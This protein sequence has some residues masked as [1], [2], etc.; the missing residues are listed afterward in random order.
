MTKVSLSLSKVYE[1][2][3]LNSTIRRAT[4]YLSE[5]MVV[6]MTHSRKPRKRD[7]S[8]TLITTIGKPNYRERQFIANCRKAKEPFPIKKIQIQYFP[9][10]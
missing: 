2:L 7:K 6:K 8:E 3:L 9:K 1:T 10:K 5:S 4:Y